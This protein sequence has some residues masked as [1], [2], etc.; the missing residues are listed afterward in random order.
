MVQ[1]DSET[2]IYH[3]AKDHTHAPPNFHTYLRIG[4][5]SMHWRTM[6]GLTP[7]G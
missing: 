3:S 7:G 4:F 5:A 1:K 2:Q 6:F